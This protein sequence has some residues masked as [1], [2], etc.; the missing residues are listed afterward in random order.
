M[1]KF[2]VCRTGKF[3]DVWFE[4][5]EELN[6]FTPE[7]RAATIAHNEFRSVSYDI[8]RVQVFDSNGALLFSGQECEIPALQ[9]S[10]LPY[11]IITSGTLSYRPS[12][13][14]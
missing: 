10:E 3:G 2:I 5:S 9:K 6:K 11:N 1:V 7:E 12:P 8:Q 4:L 13:S 14:G